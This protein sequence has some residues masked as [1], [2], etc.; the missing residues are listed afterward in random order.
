MKKFTFLT[1][2]LFLLNQFSFAQNQYQVLVERPN[3]KTLKGIISREVLLNDTSF[4]WYADNL[5]GYKPNQTALEGFKNQKDS[6]QLIAFMGTWCEDSQNVIPKLFSLL[7]QADFST[8]RITLIGV[9]RKKKTLSHLSEAL[10]IDKVPTIIVMKNGKEMGRVI[11]FGKFGLFDMDL[12]EI[13][14]SL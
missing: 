11:E 7:D 6:I 12:G 5:K 4:H 13:I 3:E 1:G 8:E 14:K 9:D 2:V 10:N